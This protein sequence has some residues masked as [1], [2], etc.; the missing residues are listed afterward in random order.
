M[1]CL[2]SPSENVWEEEGREEGGGEEEEEEEE[3][4]NFHVVKR[5]G[6]CEGGKKRGREE[7]REGGREET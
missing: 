1:Q 7:G 6:L 3:G 4:R 5:L 2:I